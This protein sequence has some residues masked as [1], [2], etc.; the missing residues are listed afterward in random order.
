MTRPK[1]PPVLIAALIT[2]PLGA[3]MFG[4][5]ANTVGGSNTGLST[6]ALLLALLTIRFNWARLATVAVLLLLTIMWLP[7]ALEYVDSDDWS[8]QYAAT[9]VLLATALSAAGAILA[10]RPS[11][12]T[13]YQQ[14]AAWRQH[15]RTPTSTEEPR[16][17]AAGPDSGDPLAR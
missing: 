13:Y 4:T 9:Y 5:A 17:R 10:F 2:L 6:V 16:V 11:S 3:L 7:G 15:R 14:A 1:R 8:R 12:N